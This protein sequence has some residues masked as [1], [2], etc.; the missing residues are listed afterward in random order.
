MLKEIK[1]GCIP[2]LFLQMRCST[3]LCLPLAFPFLLLFWVFGSTSARAI[4]S[5]RTRH[6][7]WSKS[8]GIVFSATVANVSMAKAHAQSACPCHI[9]IYSTINALYAAAK[10]DFYIFFTELCNYKHSCAWFNWSWITIIFFIYCS[11]HN[12][13]SSCKGVGKDPIL[14]RSSVSSRSP[15]PSLP[16]P[17]STTDSDSPFRS[18]ISIVYINVVYDDLKMAVV[19]FTSTNACKSFSDELIR[20]CYMEMLKQ[21]QENGVGGVDIVAL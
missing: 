13:V 18:G 12:F 7:S 21:L 19:I 5:T 17:A 16:L 10:Y 15:R 4:S 3:F 6:A 11:L 8:V 2:L 14:H 9:L 20:L 1:N